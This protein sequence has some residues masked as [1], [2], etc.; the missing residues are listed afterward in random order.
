MPGPLVDLKNLSNFKNIFEMSIKTL[1]AGNRTTLQDK[2]NAI[3]K[4]RQQMQP[5]GDFIRKAIEQYS[6]VEDFKKADLIHNLIKLADKMDSE[7]NYIAANNVDSI[8]NTM[9][10]E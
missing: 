10:E 8:I 5:F 6:F 9:L 7:K 2:V 4:L 3:K 1:E